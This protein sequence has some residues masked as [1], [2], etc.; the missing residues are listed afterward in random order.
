MRWGRERLLYPA[1]HH[2]KLRG[3]GDAPVWDSQAPSIRPGGRHIPRCCPPRTLCDAAHP[4]SLPD[5][6]AVG[7]ARC[8]RKSSGPIQPRWP[9][10]T[11]VQE[12]LNICL[13]YES[14]Q[15]LSQQKGLATGREFVL[16]RLLNPRE[17]EASLQKSEGLM[18]QVNSS[19]EDAA[20]A[21]ATSTSTTTVKVSSVHP[22]CIHIDLISYEFT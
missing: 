12:I 17:Y 4:P 10:P 5:L 16:Q 11:N 6:W 22:S 8:P 13:A 15:T 7:D 3:P 14:A 21:G 18:A 2:L 19:G 1:V 20:T 9:I